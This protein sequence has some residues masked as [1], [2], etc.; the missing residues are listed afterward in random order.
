MCGCESYFWDKLK[1][2]HKD[3]FPRLIHRSYFNRHRKHLYPFIEQLNQHMAARLNECEDVYLGDPIP[4]PVCKIAR[5]KQSKICKE[6]FE[7]QALTS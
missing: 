3:D 1:F 2:D 7:T 6:D 4:V 5:E